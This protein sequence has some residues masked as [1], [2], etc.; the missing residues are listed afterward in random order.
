MTDDDAFLDDGREN[1]S[2]AWYLH[3]VDMAALPPENRAAACLQPFNDDDIAGVAAWLAESPLTDCIVLKGDGDSMTTD[4]L[5]IRW[6]ED[7]AE[8]RWSSSNVSCCK[9]VYLQSYIAFLRCVC[10]QPKVTCTAHACTRHA[11]T[12][13]AL[14]RGRRFAMPVATQAASAS[15]IFTM[16]GAARCDRA[17]QRATSPRLCDLS[18]SVCCPAE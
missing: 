6:S 16:E 4:L 7:Q 14:A 17:A 18:P 5:G 12:G 2:S 10:R 8:G 9:K 11:G 15:S 1:V 3:L 13:S